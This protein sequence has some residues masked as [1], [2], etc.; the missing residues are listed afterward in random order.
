MRYPKDNSKITG[1]KEEPWHIRYLGIDVATKVHE[2]GI[3][4]DEYVDLYLTDY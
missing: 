1:Y 4:Y 3:T 2:A